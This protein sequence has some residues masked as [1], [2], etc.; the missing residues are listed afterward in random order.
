M[1]TVPEALKEAV[2]HYQAGNLQQAERIYREILQVDPR[3]VPA[4]HLLGLVAH[5][6][7]RNDFALHCI[8][9]ALRLQPNFVEA[10]LNLGLVLAALGRLEEAVAIRHALQ[11]AGAAP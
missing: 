8:G 2:R 10:R 7:G 9:E 1:T 5:Q 6:A 11:S 3:N 4:L